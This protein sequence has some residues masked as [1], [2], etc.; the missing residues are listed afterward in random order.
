MIQL[1]TNSTIDITSDSI[2]M[3]YEKVFSI[4][5]S[6]TGTVLAN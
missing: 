5:L 6:K 3:E 4:Y 2:E 1:L